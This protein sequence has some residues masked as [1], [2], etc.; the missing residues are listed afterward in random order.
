MK[1]FDV[2]DL[3]KKSRK[4]SKRNQ[5]PDRVGDM[6]LGAGLTLAV[7]GILIHRVMKRRKLRRQA[8]PLRS[9]LTDRVNA[10]QLK[11]LNLIWK[12]IKV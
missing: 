10:I 3:T 5:G 1:P 9:F 11:L 8:H 2:P 6:L 12:G 4:N 7:E